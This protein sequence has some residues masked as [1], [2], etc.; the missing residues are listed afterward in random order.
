[1]NKVK[2]FSGFDMDFNY[3]ARQSLENEINQF[4][5]THEIVSVSICAESHGRS[6]YTYIAAVTYKER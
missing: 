5:E 1:M 3:K 6:S 2:F 4:G